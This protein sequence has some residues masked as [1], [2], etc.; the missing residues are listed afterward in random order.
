MRP[1]GHEE[2]LTISQAELS[3]FTAASHDRNPLHLDEGYASRTP[4]GRRV[5]YGILAALACFGRLKARPGFTL[6]HVSI[7]FQRPVF[8]N[9]SYRLELHDEHADE[10]T[11]RLRDGSALLLRAQAS[12]QPGAH[13]LLAPGESV[14]GRSEALDLSERDITPGDLIAGRYSPGR[15]ALQDVSRRYGLEDRGLSQV[16]VATLLLSS[17]LVGMEL[18]GKRALFS[19]LALDFGPSAGARAP[20]LEYNGSVDD[21]DERFGLVTLQLGVDSGG[22][23]ARGELRAFLRPAPPVIHRD[24][25]V[26]RLPPGEG[27]RGKVAVVIGGSRGLGGALSLGLALQ[28]CRVIATFHQARAAAETLAS[29]A[30]AAATSGTI[31]P[32]Q[33]DA[34]DPV[35]L[36]ALRSELADGIDFLI[37]SASPPLLAL[38]FDRAGVARINAFIAAAVSLVSTPLAALSGLL[39]ARRGLVVVV[40]SAAVREGLVEW[41]HYV[42]AKCAIEGLTRVA[43]LAY[44][45]VGFLIAR[46][47]RLLTDMTN[48]P[49][50]RRG[51]LPA[52]WAAATILRRLL[53]A[54][55][56]G[57]VQL[58]E[59]FP[60]PEED[61]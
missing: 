30:I 4:Y 58:I 38:P 12:F 36:E 31:I 27:L 52:E 10:A 19:R 3:L 24:S 29:E 9:V 7:D 28:G 37:C 23:I 44:K 11:L 32:H 42:A 60:E 41:P 48:T 47:P 15:P 34:G 14:V 56:S 13:E 18:P 21:R 57:D 53:S 20:W 2:S 49:M 55:V 54:P 5:S 50:G 40:S 35:A 26:A 51:A 25:L 39:G 43:A 16:Q 22:P 33:L 6:S 59:D 8:P 1:G 45:N 61:A 17:Y 46:P